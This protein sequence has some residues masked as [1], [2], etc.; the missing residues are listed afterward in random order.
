MTSRRSSGSSRDERAVEPMRSQNITLSGRRSAEVSDATDAFGR[1]RRPDRDAVSRRVFEAQRGDRFQQTGGDGRARLTP[2]SL[3]SSAVRL[4]KSSASTSFSRNAA[5][6][7]SRPSVSQP[8]RDVHCRSLVQPSRR[9][10][11]GS[12]KIGLSRQ[13]YFR[14]NLVVGSRSDRRIIGGPPLS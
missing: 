9:A 2:I 8:V 1:M 7:R 3:R 13:D 5:S 11:H 12:F 14:L 6:Y 10:E 4:G